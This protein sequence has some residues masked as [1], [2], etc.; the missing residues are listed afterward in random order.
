MDEEARY[1]TCST[2]ACTGARFF[3]ALQ[4]TQGHAKGPAGVHSRMSWTVGE[5]G[6]LASVEDGL[7]MRHVLHGEFEAFIATD[8]IYVASYFL[9]SYAVFSAFVF[10]IACRSFRINLSYLPYS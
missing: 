9:T 3:I 7:L 5:K 8:D 4:K 10:S 1:G 2:R 6:K